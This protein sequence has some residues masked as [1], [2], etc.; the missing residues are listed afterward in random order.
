M[1][2]R[3]LATRDNKIAV[4]Q[5]ITECGTSCDTTH[6]NI[7]TKVTYI[8]F[9][10]HT[11]ATAQESKKREVM[12]STFSLATLLLLGL[13]T[14]QVAAR[15]YMRTMDAAAYVR[16]DFNASVAM[17]LR[18]KPGRVYEF[19]TPADTDDDH[20]VNIQCPQPKKTQKKGFLTYLSYVN[21]FPDTPVYVYQLGDD[22]NDNQGAMYSARDEPGYGSLLPLFCSN[23]VLTVAFNYEGT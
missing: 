14:T 18:V 6:Q 3:E 8:S 9:H 15:G 10:A 22:Y 17:P 11:E 19:S 5:I 2:D 13:C 4:N 12:I 23:G 16:D 21:S 1:R 7:H 20:F